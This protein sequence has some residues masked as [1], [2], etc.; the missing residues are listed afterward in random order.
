MPYFL[1]IVKSNRQQIANY[2]PTK[3]PV[4]TKGGVSLCCNP[5]TYNKLQEGVF[6]F[7][8]V[9]KVENTLL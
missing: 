7:I 4:H 3:K 6:R 1:P 8:A 5:F 9:A 2:S